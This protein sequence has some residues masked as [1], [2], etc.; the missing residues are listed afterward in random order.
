MSIA[1]KILILVAT[2]AL[3][4]TAVTINQISGVSNDN[5]VYSGSIPISAT[6]SLFFTYYGVDDQMNQAYLKNYPLLI[7]VGK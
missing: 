3:V 5:L 1:F 4:R 7:F 6:D 2:I